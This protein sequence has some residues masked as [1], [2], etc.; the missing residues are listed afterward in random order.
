MSAHIIF[1]ERSKQK[2]RALAITTASARNFFHTKL[3][4]AK[5]YT[6]KSH[7]QNHNIHKSSIYATYYFRYS[8]HNTNFA[9]EIQKGAALLHKDMAVHLKNFSS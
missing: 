7:Q 1:P 3:K 9:A 2:L 4:Q 6:E 5:S 8:N